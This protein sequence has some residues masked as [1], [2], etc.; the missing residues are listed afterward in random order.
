MVNDE[1]HWIGYSDQHGNNQ[2]LDS[3]GNPPATNFLWS[4]DIA[5]LNMVDAA[6]IDVWKYSADNIKIRPD[7]EGTLSGNL[8]NG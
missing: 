3:K 6:T 7:P 4:K 5:L 1:A 2:Y 8:L